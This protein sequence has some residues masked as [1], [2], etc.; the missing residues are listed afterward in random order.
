MWRILIRYYRPAPG[1][2]GPSWLAAIARSKDRLWS[3][4]LFRAE[5]ILLRSYWVLVVMD[6]YTRRIVGFG[7]E[8]ANLDGIR[9]CR[10]FNYAIARQ[11]L[12]RH[13]ST[14]NDPLFRFHRWRA[15]FGYSKSTKSRPCPPRPVRML[16]L[17][18]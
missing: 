3:V 9:V 8:A 6:V 16:S 5:S 7:V 13:L 11:T 17:S 18:V 10:M 12:P 4:D 15:T 14:D 1:G 2:N